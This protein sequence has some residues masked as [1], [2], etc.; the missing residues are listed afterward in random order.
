MRRDSKIL[1]NMVIPQSYESATSTIAKLRKGEVTSKELVDASIARIE[2]C[3]GEINAVVIRDFKRA[4]EDAAKADAD[5]SRGEEGALLGLPITMKES[6]AVAGFSKSWGI[7][8]CEKT[9]ETQ[10]GVVAAR[11]R[12]EGA[13]ILGKTNVPKLLGDW[14]T[15]N[16]IYGV[17][18][19]PWDTTKTPGGSS[20]G[21]AAALAAGYVSLE[22]GSDLNGSLRL[23]A[24][25]CGVYAHN[26]SYGLVPQRG[27]EPPGVT[28]LSIGRGLD[29]AVNGPLARSAED[30]A[31]ALK[32]IAGPDDDMATAY[33]LA[34]PKSRHDKLSDFRVLLLNHHPLMRSSCDVEAALE[35]CARHLENKGANVARSLNGL[36]DLE[37]ISRTFIPQLIAPLFA[38]VSDEAYKALQDEVSRL[39]PNDAKLD[40]LLVR[41]K[42]LTHRDFVKAG[43][44]R[45]NIRHQWRELFKDFDVVC[46]PVMPIPAF[47]HDFTGNIE[48]RTLK[49]DDRVI[50]YG[51]VGIWSSVATLT[52]QPA[53]VMPIGKSS[54]GLPIGM[55][56]IGPFLEDMT[57]ITF[58]QCLEQEFGG[59]N[60]PP[61]RLG[62]PDEGYFKNVTNYGSG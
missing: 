56:I 40:A 24:H 51:E 22:F 43:R 18:N 16:D 50:N 49:V 60:A 31:L 32:V 54:E 47:A 58:A 13:I 5:L 7:R 11:L 62:R 57:T 27:H 14:Q 46:C 52:G 19:N 26:P 20:G 23:P 28:R 61:T 1:I 45:T 21:S 8:G 2:A 48:T 44:I 59:F 4:R 9:I 55:Q 37:L 38:D 35:N 36:L 6:Y 15:F 33:R 30:L 53:T 39:D 17:T 41:S 10:D 34:L 42:V 12:K 25:C 3:D 29:F